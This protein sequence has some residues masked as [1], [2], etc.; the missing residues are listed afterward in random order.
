LSGA[1]QWQ[2]GESTIIVLTCKP[3]FLFCPKGRYFLTQTAEPGSWNPYL[4]C[5]LTGLLAMIVLSLG[6][7]RWFEKKFA[8]SGSCQIG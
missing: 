3:R 6:M 5:A 4:A 1:I 8:G 7:F 2:N